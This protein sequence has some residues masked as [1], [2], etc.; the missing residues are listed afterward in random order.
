MSKKVKKNHKKMALDLDKVKPPKEENTARYAAVLLESVKNDFRSFGEGLNLLRGE[1][2]EVKEKGDVTFEELGQFKTETA[3]KFDQ[4]DSR[5]DRID[6]RFDRIEIRLDRIEAELISIK[7]EIQELKHSL[8]K[9]A[10]IA[11]LQGLEQR[12]KVIEQ[13]LKI[14]HLAQ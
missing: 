5:F 11:K 13:T 6:S 7:T 4:I 10:D 3:V 8:M 9:K 1:V 2:R 12:V 14:R